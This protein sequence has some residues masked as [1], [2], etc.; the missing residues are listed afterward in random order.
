MQLIQTAYSKL[1]A[2]QGSMSILEPSLIKYLVGL[3]SDL[4]RY[5]LSLKDHIVQV[6]SIRPINIEY[7]FWVGV[8]RNRS[9]NH[10]QGYYVS[11]E[12]ELDNPNNS[13]LMQL[14]VNRKILLKYIVIKR[15]PEKYFMGY[16]I[17]SQ[18]EAM[19]NGNRHYIKVEFEGPQ[20]ENSNSQAK[21]LVE[22]N[23]RIIDIDNVMNG[24][25]TIRPVFRFG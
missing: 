2:P 15:R 20:S 21:P 11:Y 9:R 5:G 6:D 7:E 14:P 17:K 12:K 16:I 18:L 24:N 13:L 25:P 4:A 10:S 22:P 19:I 3:N 1:A 8:N 23:Y